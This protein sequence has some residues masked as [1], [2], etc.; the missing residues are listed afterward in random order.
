MFGLLDWHI[1]AILGLLLLVGEII[2]PG[3][4]LLFFAIGAF[5]ASIL[6]LFV[7][8][9]YLQVAVFATVALIFAFVIRPM[10]K[11]SDNENEPTNFEAMIGKKV[12]VV[13]AIPGGSGTGVVKVWGERWN[14]RADH[15]TPV[16]ATVI[17][18]AIEG[19]VLLVKTQ[20][21]EEEK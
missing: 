14:A 8:N 1:W 18:N 19:T 20:E 9:I 3:T 15:E 13:E 6:A 7:G 4:F 12:E 11:R 2:I 5:S 10:F 21:I 17:I 16:G